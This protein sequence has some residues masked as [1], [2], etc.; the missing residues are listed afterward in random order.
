MV[1]KTVIFLVTLGR[2]RTV[3]EAIEVEQKWHPCYSSQRCTGH[4][5]GSKP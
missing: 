1:I 3:K 4:P 5:A 2:M